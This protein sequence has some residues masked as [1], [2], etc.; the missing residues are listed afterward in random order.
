MVVSGFRGL[1]IERF[2]FRPLIP[3]LESQHEILQPQT[4]T[5]QDA[6]I[7]DLQPLDLQMGA[8]MLEIQRDAAPD[9][10]AIKPKPE[11]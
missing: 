8:R 10:Q 7:K 5:G 9:Y 1:R 11:T 2:G 4:C 3:E 6:A